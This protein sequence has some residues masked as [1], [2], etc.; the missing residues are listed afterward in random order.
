MNKEHGLHPGSTYAMNFKTKKEKKKL[1]KYI[2]KAEEGGV[3]TS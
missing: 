1:L 2:N 3:N